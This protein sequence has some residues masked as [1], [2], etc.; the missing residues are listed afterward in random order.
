LSC[1]VEICRVVR[2]QVAKRPHGGLASAARREY[3]CSGDLVECDRSGSVQG[4]FEAG[5]QRHHPTATDLCKLGGLS[6][7]GDSR[8]RRNYA[9]Q[10]LGSWRD[11]S[12]WKSPACA[13]RPPPPLRLLPGI[14]F[15]MPCPPSSLN[16]TLY[17]YYKANK[18]TGAAPDC[19]VFCDERVRAHRFGLIFQQGE[20]MTYL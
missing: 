17:C 12:G 7:V 4:G 11:W 13:G 20:P 14:Q 6:E 2:R 5:E 15:G 10:Q 19:L 18:A 16:A 9:R 1:L 3:A 8:G